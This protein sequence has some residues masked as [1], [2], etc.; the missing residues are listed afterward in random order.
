M[1]SFLITFATMTAA[2]V[3]AFSTSF[4]LKAA[5]VTSSQLFYASTK[6]R[7]GTSSSAEVIKAAM[8]ASTKFGVTSPE[9][10]AAWETVEVSVFVFLIQQ[11]ACFVGT[12]QHDQVH[13]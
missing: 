10:R 2:A 6:D 13:L 8:E 11:P 3:S 9:A 4:V 1:K 12:R 5:A 7:V